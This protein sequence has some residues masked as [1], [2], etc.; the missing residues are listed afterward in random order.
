MLVTSTMTVVD[1]PLHRLRN[2]R[3]AGQR[4]A[5]PAQAVAWLGALQAQD[6]ANATWAIGL[7]CQDAT[8]VTVAEA[9]AS[10][11]IIHTWLMR[12]T[13]HFAA[14]A[15]ARWMLALLR[16]G[17]LASRQRRYR[18]LELDDATFVRSFQVLEMALRDGKQ[19]TRQELMAILEQAGISAAGQRGYHMLARAAL[20]G[21]VCFGPLEGK[22]QT[23]VWLDDWVPENKKLNREE[24]LAEL[25][26][27]YFNSHGPA[28]LK[29]FIWWSGLRVADARAGLEMVRPQLREEIIDDQAFWMPP[30]APTPTIPSPA[31][32]LL[33]AFDEYYLGY[34]ARGAVLDTRFDRKVVSSNGVF[35]PMIVVDGQVVGTWQR[36]LKRDKV[37]IT[38]T[39]FRALAPAE[40]QAL[41]VAANQFGEFLGLPAALAAM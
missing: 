41:A 15:D 22:Q 40:V 25:A 16:P 7:R 28:T 10:R 37:V 19:A 34:S 13:L 35:R 24:A 29:D 2:Q 20:E 4:P 33:P 31:V 23:L 1:I 5:V 17:L 30:D 14:A 12:G 8:F 18:Q 38:S 21:L 11:T 9:I 39:P 27:R 26:L 36:A 6:Y 32:Y 3:I